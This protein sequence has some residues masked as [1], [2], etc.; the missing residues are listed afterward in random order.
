MLLLFFLPLYTQSV[1][2]QT[3]TLAHKSFFFPLPVLGYSQETGLE[4]GAVLFYSFFTD[5]ASPAPATRNSTARLIS[6]FTTNSQFKVDLKGD[7]WTRDNLYHV[8]SNLRYHNFPYYF[9]GIG[10]QTAYEERSLINQ[11]RYKLGLEA[12]RLLAR[13]FY[14]GISLEYQHDEYEAKEAS[15]IYPDMDLTDKAGGYVTFVGLTA[16]YDNRDNQNYTHSGYYFRANIAG[17]P[18][19]MSERALTRIELEGRSFFPLWPGGH[20]GVHAQFTALRGETLPFYLLPEMGDD[21]L[22]RGYYTGRYREQNY[23]A[24]QTEYRHFIDPGVRIKIAFLDLQPKFALA[25]FGGT[26]TVYPNGNFQFSALKPNYG[27][28]VRYFFEEQS[29]LTIRADYG[30]GEKRPGEKRQGGFYLSFRE[31][32]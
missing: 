14:A 6:T 11:K 8:K 3:D 25:A 20:L 28:G 9:Y 21:L 5:H 31:A 4:I 29:R 26:G 19:F 32:F 17:A 7:I 1:I 30:W 16:I 27:I 23:L 24:M 18:R 12:E 2:A 10:D 15:G 13:N 22:M